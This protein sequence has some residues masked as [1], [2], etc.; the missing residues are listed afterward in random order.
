ML[1]RTFESAYG[2]YVQYQRELGK[3]GNERA[4]TR[5][6]DTRENVKWREESVR[7]RIK[8]LENGSFEEHAFNRLGGGGNDRGNGDGSTRQK[9]ILDND[10]EAWFIFGMEMPCSYNG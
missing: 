3:R 10:G 2:E 8:P 5:A 7:E 4:E 9:S 6:E 1:L